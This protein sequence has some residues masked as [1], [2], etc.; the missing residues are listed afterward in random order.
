MNRSSRLAL[1]LAMSIATALLLS[2]CTRQVVKEVAVPAPTG[3][4][5]TIE[6]ELT[7]AGPQVHNPEV[8]R[9]PHDF[10]RWHNTT[11]TSF[12]L[13]FVDKPGTPEDDPGPFQGGK[14]EICV[15][16]GAYTGW[17]RIR[18]DL[19]DKGKKISFYYSG[20][21][22]LEGPPGEPGIIVGD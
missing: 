22:H 20:N 18:N 12:T 6:I 19:A 8:K 21:P 5:N 15:P 1:A 13:T 11:S 16:A 14:V 10:V 3:H 17:F 7:S 9:N 4:D 2:S